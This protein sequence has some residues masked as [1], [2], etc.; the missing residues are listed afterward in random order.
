ML[1]QPLINVQRLSNFQGTVASNSTV[2]NTIPTGGSIYG[3]F[4]RCLAGTADA[5]IANIAADIAR[6]LVR[7]DGEP[8]LDATG[9]QIQ[10]LVNFL[11]GANGANVTNGV[12]PLYFAQWGKNGSGVGA[13]AVGTWVAASAFKL[14]TLNVGQITVDVTFNSAALTVTAVECY[15]QRTDERVPLGSH[16]RYLPYPQAF[17]GTGAYEI[18]TLPKAPGTGLLDLHIF[19]ANVTNATV[20]VNNVPVFDQVPTTLNQNILERA[21]F[22]PQTGVFSISMAL[23]NTADAF[24]PFDGV[25]D[26]RVAPTFSS[27][28]GNFTIMQRAIFNV[29]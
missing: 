21:G 29:A 7:I 8:I 15:V 19:N 5:T 11:G 3:I 17:S 9:A 22:D 6:V 16:V 18:S 28:P 1:V 13:S 2:T 14:G 12:L 25:T 23:A 4:L 24:L 26:Y 10:A 27:A 20:K